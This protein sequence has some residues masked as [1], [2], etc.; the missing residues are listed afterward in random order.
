[1]RALYEAM[2]AFSEYVDARTPE[3]DERPEQLTQLTFLGKTRLEW[4]NAGPKEY[5]NY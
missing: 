4:W 1:M 5:L 3:S 2:V